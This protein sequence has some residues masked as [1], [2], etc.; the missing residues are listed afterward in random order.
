MNVLNRLQLLVFCFTG[1]LLVACPDSTSTPDSGA[2]EVVEE[3]V[4]DVAKETGPDGGPECTQ[5]ADCTTSNPCMIAACVG[6]LCL[7]TEALDGASCSD[8]PGC[9]ASCASGVC[10]TPVPE[11]TCD[12]RACGAD[13]CG[14]S[15]GTCPAGQS[16]DEAS[17]TCSSADPCNGITFDGC[18]TADGVAQWC[19]TDDSGQSYLASYDCSGIDTPAHWCGWTGSLGYYCDDSQQTDPG[20]LSLLCP[21]ESCTKA[22]TDADVQCGFLCGEDCGSCGDGSFCNAEYQCETCAPDHCGGGCGDCAAG[23]ICDSSP[24]SPTC[25]RWATTA[26]GAARALSWFGAA[27][28]LRLRSIAA[29]TAADGMRRT[30]GT[31]AVSPAQIRAAPPTSAAGRRPPSPGQRS[32]R[33]WNRLRGQQMSAMTQRRWWRHRLRWMRAPAMQAQRMWA[34]PTLVPGRRTP[35][36]GIRAR[37]TPAQAT[38]VRVTLGL[39]AE[40]E[41]DLA[42]A[43]RGP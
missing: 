7:E 24:A 28:A 19:D 5:D 35:R 40:V 38:R 31:T 27:K 13:S 15:C 43:R 4:Q 20:G 25:A 9:N 32:P 29:A 2:A 8:T 33:W 37:E 41:G 26:R 22:C 18:C 30:V 6:N 1:L 42:I 21:G 11:T 34:R 3:V 16:C 17:G 14:T 36:R 10:G 23:F 39:T 12:G